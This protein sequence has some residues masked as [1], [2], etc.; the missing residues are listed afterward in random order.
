M[1]IAVY[2][3]RTGIDPRANGQAL[4]EAVQQAARE[5]A[6]ILFTPEMSGM[7]DRDRERAA[8]HLHPEDE[9]QV[10]AAVRDA[11]AQNGLWVHLG[12]LALRGGEAGKLVNRGFVIDGSGSIRARYD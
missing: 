11:A 7:L 9:D 6:A 2:Q 8:A 1:K 3:A 4:V 10:L 5:G 12:S